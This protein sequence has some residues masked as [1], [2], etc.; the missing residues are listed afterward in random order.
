MWIF[1][2]SCRYVDLKHTNPGGHML[3]HSKH[4]SFLCTNL[5]SL[6]PLGEYRPITSMSE[7]I[8]IISCQ[9]VLLS[10]W[11]VTERVN[12]FNYA[13]LTIENKPNIGANEY[14]GPYC[15]WQV[16]RF[17]GWELIET[18]LYI[19]AIQAKDSTF[20]VAWE[21]GSDTHIWPLL[22][23]SSSGVQKH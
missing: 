1:A 5:F 14:S 12:I 9:G 22:H 19:T 10:V 17:T 6:R 18:F 21:Q 7:W 23:R 8:L 4:F 15:V 16:S 3:F 20:W 13:V 11:N 2:L